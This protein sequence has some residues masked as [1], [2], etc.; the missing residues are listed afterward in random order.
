MKPLADMTHEE[1][2]AYAKA[3]QPY[4]QSYPY[5]TLEELKADEEAKNILRRRAELNDTK[6][7]GFRKLKRWINWKFYGKLPDAEYIC[8]PVTEQLRRRGLWE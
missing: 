6:P 1:L 3:K 7:R 4:E 5:K 2:L 8:D